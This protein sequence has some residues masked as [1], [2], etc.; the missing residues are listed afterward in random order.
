MSSVC[1][2]CKHADIAT[3]PRT[4]VKQ[5]M[6]LVQSAGG[7]ICTRPEIKEIS[8]TDGEMRCSGYEEVTGNET[9]LH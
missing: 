9:Q 5:G 6:T 3:K 7:V 2:T 8:I 4:I 1:K